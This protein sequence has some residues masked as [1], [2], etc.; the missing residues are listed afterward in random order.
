MH[1]D[2]LISQL[3]VLLGKKCIVAMFSCFKKSEKKENPP[4]F[5]HEIKKKGYVV[6]RRASAFLSKNTR[7][8]HVA[9]CC[10]GRISHY[11]ITY[12]FKIVFREN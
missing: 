10:D 7:R 9:I 1:F 5:I 4:P 8:K 12:Y 2:G 6:N 3:K 11:S